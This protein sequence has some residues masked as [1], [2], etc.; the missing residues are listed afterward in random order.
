MKTYKRG[1]RI[2]KIE[3]KMEWIGHGTAVS[4]DVKVPLKNV[5]EPPSFDLQCHP[6]E[7]SLGAYIGVCKH[8]YH[9]VHATI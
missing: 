8:E 4:H 9:C 5:A 3:L 2:P 7:I 1:R 6:E